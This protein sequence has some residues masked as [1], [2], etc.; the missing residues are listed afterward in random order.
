METADYIRFVLAFAA[1]IGL[2]LLMW[3]G[4]RRFGPSGT[5]LMTGRERRLAIVE[6]LPI[7]TRR[8]LV[9]IRRDGTE[10]LVMISQTGESVI[11]SGIT[12]P[13]SAA[14]PTPLP[15]AAE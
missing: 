7:D 5:G 15:E 14:A 6:V 11:E 9:L 8:R 2:I 12:P 10:H 13:R 1:V 3:A 4:L